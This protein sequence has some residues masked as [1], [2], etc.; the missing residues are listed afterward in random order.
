MTKFKS[1]LDLSDQEL[2][3][4]ELE[5]KKQ[6]FTLRTE[7]HVNRALENPAQITNAKKDIARI[8]TLR[9]QRNSVQ[10]TEG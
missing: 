8:K 3:A 7:L 4:K 2:E 9:T 5:L 10:S 6:I 1:L